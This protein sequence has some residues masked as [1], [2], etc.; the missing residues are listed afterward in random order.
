MKRSL[1]DFDQF[2]GDSEQAVAMAVDSVLQAVSRADYGFKNIPI[3]YV[4]CGLP[5]FFNLRILHLPS[6]SDMKEADSTDLAARQQLARDIRDACIN[7]GFFYVKNH[8]IPE[9]DI[10]GAIE[11]GK[12]FFA[13]PEE[14][15]LKVCVWVS[16]VVHNRLTLNTS[17]YDVNL[18]PSFKGYNALLRQ[19]LDP[20]SRGDLHEAFNIGPERS[21][22]AKDG[23][24]YTNQWPAEVDGFKEGYLGY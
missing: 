16:C 18:H 12:T 4:Q 21:E 24:P 14:T 15:K 3:M 10:L 5:R 1:S 7:V 2:A 11:A 13:L 9:E 20:E 22:P 6:I 23:K 19:N 17:K 8:G